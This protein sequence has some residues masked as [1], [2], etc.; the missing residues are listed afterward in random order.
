VLEYAQS[1]V[2][3]PGSCTICLALM[4]SEKRVLEVRQAGHGAEAGSQTGSQRREWVVH[5][6]TYRMLEAGRQAAGQE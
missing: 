1:A 2:D 6:S 5:C 3:V 4:R